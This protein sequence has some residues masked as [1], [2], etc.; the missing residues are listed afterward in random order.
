[1]TNLKNLYVNPFKKVEG[2]Q[3]VIYKQGVQKQT[4]VYVRDSILY[5]NISGGY[6]TLYADKGSSVPSINWKGLINT[7]GETMQ[8]TRSATNFLQLESE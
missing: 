5:A 8:F 2:L 6:V 4:D 3:V 1:M 7:Q